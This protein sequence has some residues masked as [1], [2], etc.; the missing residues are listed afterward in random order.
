MMCGVTFCL[1]GSVVALHL[2]N[3]AAKAYSCNQG[4]TVFLSLS[5][6][7]FHILNLASK[8]AVTL[9][10]AYIYM[11]PLG[12]EANHGESWFQKG[13]FVLT[14]FKQCF[15]FGVNQIWICWNPHILI[16]INIITPWKIQFL[17]EPLG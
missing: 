9:I 5:R 1:S 6:P 17:W 13:I 3:N 12:V 11:Y 15:N 16:N 14:K 2:D 4:G 8:H 7:A 10:P